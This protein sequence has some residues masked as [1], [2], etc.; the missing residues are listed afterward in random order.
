MK[1]LYLIVFC[2]GLFAIPACQSGNQASNGPTLKGS[3]DAQ[4]ITDL[5][6]LE[7]QTMT[8]SAKIKFTFNEDNT[9]IYEAKIMTNDI[10][11]QG[12]YRIAGDSLFIYD[13]GEV[14]DGKF[15]LT[16]KGD[17]QWVIS[18]SGNFLL[19]PSK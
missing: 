9:A 5:Q 15:K 13:L 4:I 14:P 18:G 12:K 1:F 8:K 3:Y 2:C 17:N 10:H 16:A 11:T 6:D 7:I 19:T